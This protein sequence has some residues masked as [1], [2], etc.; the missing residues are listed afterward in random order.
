MQK[1]KQ[2]KF[3][4]KKYVMHNSN[5]FYLALFFLPLNLFTHIIS[6]PLDDTESMFHL[7]SFFLKKK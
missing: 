1:L 3:L 7:E 5:I 6:R 4:V 2:H